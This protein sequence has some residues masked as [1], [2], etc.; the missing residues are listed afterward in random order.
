MIHMCSEQCYRTMCAEIYEKGESESNRSSCDQTASGVS[1]KRI[2]YFPSFFPRHH[3]ISPYFPRCSPFKIKTG[4]GDGSG[5]KRET[6]LVNSLFFFL[7][8]SSLPTCPEPARHRRPFIFLFLPPYRLQQW[9]R[10]EEGEENGRFEAS[11]EQTD[12]GW[13]LFDSAVMANGY[14]HKQHRHPTP[15]R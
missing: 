3:C 5:Q 14:T 10:E 4:G 15:P 12:Q 9:G 6:F 8:P 13:F 1:Q 11:K 2:I 7:R